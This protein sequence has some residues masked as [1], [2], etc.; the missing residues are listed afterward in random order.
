MK[1]DITDMPEKLSICR[2][3][4]LSFS[5]LLQSEAQLEK[6][7]AHCGCVE[8]LDNCDTYIFMGGNNYDTAKSVSLRLNAP[9]EDV[10]YM[11]VGQE[12]I[13]RRGQKPIIT[14]RYDI[15]ND[16]FYQKITNDYEKNLK[17]QI[18]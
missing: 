13:F 14:R 15:K 10:L 16:K 3:K 7:Y 12:I 18:R 8:I 5:L 9:F 4:G 17:Q 2:E 1:S 11:P 6:M